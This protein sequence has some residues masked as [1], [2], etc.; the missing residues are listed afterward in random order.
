LRETLT[1]RE[2]EKVAGSGVLKELHAGLAFALED[3]ARLMIVI[4]DNTATNM[5]IDRLGCDAVNARMQN[6]GLDQTRLE[7]R[8]FDMEA[9]APGFANGI[10]PADMALLLLKMERRE[11]ISP[12]ACEAMLAIM[13][14]QQVSSK[15][16]RLLPPD[17]PI[18]HKTGTVS[19]ASHDVGII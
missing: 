13:R 18:A 14:R 1:L 12:D 8:L 7:R 6:L 3:L 5:L 11:L 9:R 4:S 10:S 19:N 2:E 17:T 16:P 15:M